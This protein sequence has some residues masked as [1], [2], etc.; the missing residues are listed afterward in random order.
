MLS[1]VTYEKLGYET[2]ESNARVAEHLQLAELAVLST[3]LEL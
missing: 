1:R 2:I 3:V